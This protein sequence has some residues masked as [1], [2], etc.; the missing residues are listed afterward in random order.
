MRDTTG[1]LHSIWA[2]K[3]NTQ[4]F[5]FL[6]VPINGTASGQNYKILIIR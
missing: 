5:L 4:F 3:E 1:N 6:N 2:A